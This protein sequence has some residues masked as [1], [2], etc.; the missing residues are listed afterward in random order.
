MELYQVQD[1]SNNNVRVSGCASKKEARVKRD[2]LQTKTKAGMPAAD[3][4]DDSSSWQYSIG[5]GKDHRSF[6]GP[7]V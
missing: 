6:Q 3:K 7:K 2:E 5:L 1:K 4:R